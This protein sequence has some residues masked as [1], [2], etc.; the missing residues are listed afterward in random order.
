MHWFITGGCGFIGS[1]LTDYLTTARANVTILDN[2]S[3]GRAENTPN[4]D[5][6]EGD[7]RDAAEVRRLAADVDVI[8]HLAAMSG[9]APSVAAPREC[10]EIN[11]IGTLNVLE[12]ARTRTI[13]VV[14]ASSGAVGQGAVASPYGASKAALEAYGHAYAASYALPVRILRFSS[15]YGSG[16]R[17]KSSVVAAFARAAL[18]GHDLVVYGDGHQT[19]D[20]VYV[21]DVA[22]AILH[23]AQNITATGPFQV[24]SGEHLSVN[25]VVEQFRAELPN[26]QC[27]YDPPLPGEVRH[28]TSDTQHLP[29]WEAQVAF[30][31]GLRLTIDYFR[32]VLT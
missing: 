15:V 1:A 19:R 32:E 3:V 4:A 23:A 25:Q 27:C 9:V 13:P 8:V 11:I 18:Q 31:Q 21:T 17:D 16:S 14:L 12:A 10:T 20:F 30:Q 6:H 26:I 24:A 5:I 29:G 28:S 22:R 2:F 7:V